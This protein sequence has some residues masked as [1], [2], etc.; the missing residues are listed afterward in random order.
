MQRSHESVLC[1][2]AMNNQH[3]N[4][5]LFMYRFIYLWKANNGR[6]RNPD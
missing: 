1:K 3:N 2:S 6:Y 4:V 5:L